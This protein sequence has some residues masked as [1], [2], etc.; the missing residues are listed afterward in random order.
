MTI[1]FRNEG[2]PIRT[3]KMIMLIDDEPFF[4]ALL[5]EFLEERGYAV[6]TAASG[7]EGLARAPRENPDLILLDVLM[8]GLDGF[9]V[10]TQL[11]GD[12]ATQPIPVVL[13]TASEDPK[14]HE[15]AVQAGAAAVIPKVA[16]RERLLHVMEL[17]LPREKKP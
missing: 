15:K 6:C 13:L 17:L 16:P 2:A 5:R 1:R 7:E 8:P 12:P 10:C 9:E 11:K 3:Q 4:L 14:L